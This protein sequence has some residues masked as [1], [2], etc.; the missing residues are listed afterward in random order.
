MIF[1]DLLLAFRAL[2]RAPAFSI[3]AIVTMALGIGGTSAVFTIVNSI[4]LRPLPYPAADRLVV[5]QHSAPGLGL[6]GTSLSDATYLHYRGESRAFEDVGYYYENVVNVTGDG[7][8]E[9]VQIAM[10]SPSLL[11]TLG[12]RTA[13]GRLFAP[14]D[15]NARPSDIVPVVISHELWLRRYGGDPAIVGRVIRLNSAARLVV[16]VLERGFHFPRRETQIWFADELNPARVTFTDFRYPTVARLRP[17]VDLAEAEAELGRLNAR[18]PAAYPEVTRE[19]L[20]DGRFRTTVTPLARVVVGD[21][22]NA[23]WLLLAG[24]GFVLLIACTNVAN[25]F[26]VRAEHRQREVAVRCALGANRGAVVRYFLSESVL[27]GLAAGALGLLIAD[28]ATQLLVAFGPVTLPRLHE[29]EVDGAVLGFTAVLA[30]VTALVFGAVPAARYG[31]PQLGAGLRQYALGVTATRERQRIRQLLV[32]TQIALAL[33]LVVGSALMVQSFWKLRQL[34]PGFD[35]DGV[36]TAEIAL[37]YGPYRD[38]EAATALWD[39]LL[40]GVRALPGVQAAGGVSGLPLVPAPEYYNSP[41]ELADAPEL[42]EAARAIGTVY[43]VTPGYFDAMR[44]P[45]LEG[46]PLTNATA[47]ARNGVVVSSALARRLFPG[48][49]AVG[50]RLRTAGGDSAWHTIIAVVG[51]VPRRELA[52]A[53]AELLYVPVAVRSSTSHLTLAVR[54][55]A[56]ETVAPAIRALVRQLDPDLPVA[57][58][59]TMERI[60]ADSMARTSFAMVT[61]L[62]AGALALFLGVVGIY[63]VIAYTISRRFREIGV[64]MALGARAAD[65]RTLILRRAAAV[66]LIG[67]AV[68][69]ATALGLTRFLRSLL[70]DVSPTDPLTLAGM[71][72]LLLASALVAAWIPARRIARTEPLVVLR[73][74]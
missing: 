38:S 55:A 10:V 16:G 5:V 56:P 46:R 27:L 20:T 63:G 30:V 7:D 35:A 6:A 50:R 14:D 54:A 59:R 67:I 28:S 1:Q 13:R 73:L 52:G 25:L 53:P 74:D 72:A 17:G 69:I 41:L 65:I 3:V 64:R 8:A 15:L 61:L 23:L 48:E 26:L 2:R 12:A 21:L 49:R 31:K 44:I 60:V 47:D 62:I 51:D 34:D 42:A 43:F 57:N 70:F 39:R 58:V 45:V 9:R 37:P 33:T 32:V 24:M 19:L 40:D 11:T 36:L 66:S 68:G 22:S 71:A 29:I 18:L 4:V